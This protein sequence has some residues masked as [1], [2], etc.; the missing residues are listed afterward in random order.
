MSAGSGRDPF[1][2][3]ADTK[4]APAR[5]LDHGDLLEF[6]GTTLEVVATPG[7]TANHIS[8]GISGTRILLTGDHVMGWNST[9]VTSPEG[10]LAAYLASMERLIA[11][12]WDYYLPA[13]G[14]PVEH[15]R[16]F[17]QALRDH[18]LAR[19]EQILVG[20]DKGA[21][22]VKSLLRRIYPKLSIRLRLAARWTLVAHIDYLVD[23]GDLRWRWGLFGKRLVR[24]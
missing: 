7:H 6:G 2:A 11:S 22:E 14:G 23:R 24:T 1:A 8:F 17:A 12:E 4:L 16:A 20:V 13:H 3:A 10:S 19:I 15:G 21:N 9:L 18:R 5:Q